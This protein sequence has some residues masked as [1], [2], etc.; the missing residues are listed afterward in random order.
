MDVEQDQRRMEIAHR[1]QCRS[2]VRRLTHHVEPI[3]L[4]QRAS[5]G[6]KACVI[7]DD[8][9]ARSQTRIVSPPVNGRL[10]ANPEHAAHHEP[11]EWHRVGRR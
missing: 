5:E 2:A 10:R 4:E 11:S 6:T 1:D 8:Q 9:N 3:G 7:V